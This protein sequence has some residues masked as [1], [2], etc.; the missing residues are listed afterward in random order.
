MKTL[1]RTPVIALMS[2]C[3][4]F[5]VSLAQTPKAQDDLDEVAS[6]AMRQKV[7]SGAMA[8]MEVILYEM[9]GDKAVPVLDT[10]R[11]FK[12][13]DELR[14]EFKSSIEGYVYLVNVSPEGKKTVI[15]PDIRFNNNNRVE[16]GR[17]YRLPEEEVMGFEGDEKGDEIIQVIMSAQRIPFFEKAIKDAKGELGK[18]SAAAAAELISMAA[19]KKSGIQADTVAKVLPPNSQE[20][21]LSR[22]MKLKVFAPKDKDEQGTVIA[23]PD[24]LKGG[25]VAVFEIR[26]RHM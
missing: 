4:I 21:V 9:K 19:K 13:S 15:F 25:G 22:E 12:N 26:I 20:E 11:V 24:G 5:S 18:D 7:R 14:V 1:F 3:A 10:G 2:L 23:I 17:T 8:G 6:R 16:K